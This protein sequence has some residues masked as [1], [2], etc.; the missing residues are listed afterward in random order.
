M[1]YF[2]IQKL[3]K[4]LELQSEN[5]SHMS[6]ELR[7]KLNSLWDRLQIDV[8]HRER[9]VCTKKGIGKKVIQEVCT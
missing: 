2:F 9:F 5:Q 7:T 4:R 3:I 1:Y 6:M 8:T